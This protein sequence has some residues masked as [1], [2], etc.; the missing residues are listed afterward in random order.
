MKTS[1]NSKVTPVTPV[2][3]SFYGTDTFIVT[4]TVD[5]RLILTST[6]PTA[7]HPVLTVDR[8]TVVRHFRNA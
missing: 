5:A 7:K 2:L 1:I 6:N 4:G 3:K 8:S